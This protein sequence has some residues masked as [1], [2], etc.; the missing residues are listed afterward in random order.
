MSRRAGDATVALWLACV[1]AIAIVRTVDPSQVSV[2]ALACS[3]GAMAAGRLWTL[4]TSGVIIA[5]PPVPQLLMTGIVA[6][7]VVRLAGAR[8]WWLSAVAGHFG[9]TFVAYAGIAAVYI[10]DRP[11]AEG[12]VH[13]PD[14]G[15]SAVWAATTGTL[16]V[17]LHRAGVHPRLTAVCTVALLG[18]F[19]ALVG[20]DG[21]LAD[22]E[23]LVA[24]LFGLAVVTVRSPSGKLATV[25][26]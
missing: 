19:V 22:I 14:Y 15:I 18:A 20:I 4:V 7:V 21:E 8:T 17:L 25:A 16:L 6:V 12:V 26:A 13:A 10:V 3:P 1:A 24:F 23:H 2:H 11:T 5:G 9:A